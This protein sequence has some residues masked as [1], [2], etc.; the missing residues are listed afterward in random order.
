[1]DIGS[2]I[3]DAIYHSSTTSSVIFPATGQVAVHE[4]LQFPFFQH[5]FVTGM[6]AIGLLVEK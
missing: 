3:D 5:Q 2:D 4:L 1:M 6:T